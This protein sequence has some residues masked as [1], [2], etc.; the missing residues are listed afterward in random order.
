MT[1]DKIILEC[2]YCYWMF[3]AKRPDGSVSTASLSKPHESRA[4]ETVIED[5]NVCRNP[6]CKKIFTVYWF[7]PVIFEIDLLTYLT[8]N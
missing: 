8:Q 5:S 6:K 2:P 1:E 7:Q 4:D 3:Q